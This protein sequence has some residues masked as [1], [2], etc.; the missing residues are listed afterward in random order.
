M[1]IGGSFLRIRVMTETEKLKL[2]IAELEMRIE[3]LEKQIFTISKGKNKPYYTIKE[4]ADLLSVT[5]Q[6]V[7]NQINSGGINAVK[8]G[9]SW[10]IPYKNL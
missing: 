3:S 5:P 6:T 2:R 9:K 10:R 4:Y 1:L 7:Y 8:V